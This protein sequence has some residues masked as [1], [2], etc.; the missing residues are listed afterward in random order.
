MKGNELSGKATEELHGLVRSTDTMRQIYDELQR[1]PLRLLCQVCAE[2]QRSGRAV[3]DHNLGLFSYFA[4]AS[5]RALVASGLLKQTQGSSF[6]IY[7]YEPTEKGLALH[8][9]LME[10][11]A[12]K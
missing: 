3:A 4:E 5:L 2:T 7:E 10:E 11:G 12:C 8:K 6:S 9:R 1:E